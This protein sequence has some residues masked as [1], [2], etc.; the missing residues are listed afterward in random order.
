MFKKPVKRWFRNVLVLLALDYFYPGFVVNGGLKMY[1]IGAL[2]LYLV[3]TFLHPL[4]KVM[5]L[6]VNILTLGMFK[7]LLVA[8]HLI[9]VAYVFDAIEFLPFSYE[10][11]NIF[12]IV[13]IPAGE[14]NLIFSIVL[15][16]IL[17][18]MI[19][20]VIAFLA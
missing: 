8:V 1:L 15:G 9:I 6:P 11:F 19:R 2:L 7:W 18:R 13:E 5:Y 3:Q 14:I 17:Y 16:T 10:L 20:Q 4:L 12:G